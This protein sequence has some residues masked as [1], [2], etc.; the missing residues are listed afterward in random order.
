MCSL[1]LDLALFASLS[2][3]HTAW[4]F[5]T[6]GIGPAPFSPLDVESLSESIGQA[7]WGNGLPPS[8][9]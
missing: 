8:K 3:A 2:R 5:G 9:Q 7:C 4:F 1:C 6:V